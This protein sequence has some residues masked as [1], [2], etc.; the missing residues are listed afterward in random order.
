VLQIQDR[1]RTAG[2]TSGARLAADLVLAILPALQQASV[3][4][5]VRQERA[6]VQIPILG[7]PTKLKTLAE[8]IMAAADKRP[9]DCLVPATDSQF[10][11]GRYHLPEPP[12]TGRDADGQRF[13]EDW[14]AALITAFAKDDGRFSGL[15]RQYLRERFIQRDL[16]SA[17]WAEAERELLDTVAGELKDKAED[18]RHPITFYYIVPFGSDVSADVRRQREADIAAL[19]RDFPHLAFLRLAGAAPL[20]EEVRRYGKLRSI[21]YEAS[22]PA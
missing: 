1:L 2:D 15:F 21:L 13:R 16:R 10:P 22:R 20:N 19:K 11:E 7:I 6:A 4:A 12:E 17:D 18:Q 5:K 8:I 3:I 9:A 14:R